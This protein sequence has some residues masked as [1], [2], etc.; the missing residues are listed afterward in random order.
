[1]MRSVRS[2]SSSSSESGE[3]GD[4]RRR[5]PKN[6]RVRK[7]DDVL[8][9]DSASPA[10][11]DAFAQLQKIYARLPLRWLLLAAGL[12]AAAIVGS[13]YLLRKMQSQPGIGY[14]ARLARLAFCMFAQATDCRAQLCLDGPAHE[15][16]D[17]AVGQTR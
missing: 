14:V 5:A 1:M 4:R 12:F 9:P 15:H 6:M 2:T 10:R 17:G 16:A 13:R 3:S 8:G 11:S 7:L